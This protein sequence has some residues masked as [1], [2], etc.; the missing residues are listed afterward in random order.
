MNPAHQPARSNVMLKVLNAMIAALFVSSMLWNAAS[1]APT[2]QG[3]FEAPVG[4][5]QPRVRDLPPDVQHDEGKTDP[6]DAELHRA[7]RSICRGCGGERAAHA[8][9]TGG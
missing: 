8:L 5:R 2:T 9:R 3:R 6:R 7:L 1:V 4:H